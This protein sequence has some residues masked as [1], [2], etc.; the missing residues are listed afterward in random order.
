M[1]FERLDYFL[2]IVAVFRNFLSIQ[3][4][5]FYHIP[6]GLDTGVVALTGVDV[7]SFDLCTSIPGVQEIPNIFVHIF[8]IESLSLPMIDLDVIVCVEL[9]T[10][11][12]KRELGIFF[13]HQ[14]FLVGNGTW[15][16]FFAVIRG[17]IHWTFVLELTVKD[18]SFVLLQPSF[19]QYK[20]FLAHLGSII[21]IF[22]LS[23]EVVE[24]CEFFR[25]IA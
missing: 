12:Q 22:L 20:H 10:S 13:F 25:D 3:Q 17:H 14:V 21:A 16:G 11:S 19:T 9:L 23:H 4:D 7:G 8:E 18:V 15:V 24:F 6:V 5:Y 1:Y 2:L